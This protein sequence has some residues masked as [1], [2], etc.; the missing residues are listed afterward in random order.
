MAG[1]NNNKAVMSRRGWYSNHY[2]WVVMATI[3]VVLSS[4]SSSTMIGVM[5]QQP[6][7]DQNNNNNVAAMV[8]E[9]VERI[10]SNVK[11]AASLE[12]EFDDATVKKT[13]SAARAAAATGQAAVL[14][15]MAQAKKKAT[16]V[17]NIGT[18][19]LNNKKLPNKGSWVKKLKER[20]RKLQAVAKSSSQNRKKTTEL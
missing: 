6:E 15:A 12:S 9:T 2:Y 4:S 8:Q 19:T 17:K 20:M 3:L 16:A 13:A 7:K 1:T 18:N 14:D 10:Q 11:A 5:A